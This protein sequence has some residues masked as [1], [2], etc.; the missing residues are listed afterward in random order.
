MVMAASSTTRGG[1]LTEG[2][3]G[4]AFVS[5]TAASLCLGSSLLFMMTVAGTCWGGGLENCRSG[6]LLD[7]GLQCRD[8]SGRRGEAGEGKK[9]MARWGSDGGGYSSSVLLMYGGEVMHTLGLRG[10]KGKAKSAKNVRRERKKRE[11][12][13]RPDQMSPGGGNTDDSEESNLV[14][15]TS[16][17]GKREMVKLR[18]LHEEKVQEDGSGE[19]VEEEEEDGEVDSEMERRE[20]E[21]LIAEDEADDEEY[22]E[23][24]MSDG[25][26]HDDWEEDHL[27]EEQASEVLA[28]CEESHQPIQAYASVSDQAYANLSH[29]LMRPEAE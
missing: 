14:S 1:D 22:G 19:E 12:E 25:N 29:L 16:Q 28:Q 5:R 3:K 17:N 7:D 10:G 24:L 26:S 6:W 4:G 21:R 20:M 2:T 11:R 23:G 27:D 9:R 15:V 18:P 8:A 13:D